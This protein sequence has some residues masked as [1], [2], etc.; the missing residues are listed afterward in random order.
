[1]KKMIITS[2]QMEELKKAFGD[3]SFEMQQLFMEVD[4][5]PKVELKS[6]ENAFNDL[7]LDAKKDIVDKT[8]YYRKFE[9][10]KF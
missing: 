10:K 9:K 8:P 2:K 6:L 3:F 1:M 7:I 4:E 5:M